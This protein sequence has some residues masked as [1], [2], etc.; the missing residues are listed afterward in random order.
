MRER[1]RGDREMFVP[2][3]HPPEH[4][5]ADFGETVVVV[6]GVE[7]NGTSSS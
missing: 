4:A 2:T 5:Q 1:E 6:G 7:Q 3:A